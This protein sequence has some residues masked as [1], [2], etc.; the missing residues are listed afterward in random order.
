MKR[1]QHSTGK[2]RA[3]VTTKLHVAITAASHL[4]E[5][6]LSP[7]NRADVA[8]ADELF[9]EVFGCDVVE[10]TGYDSDAHRSFLGSHNNIPVIPGRK[11][12]QIAI[13]DD[14]A[15]YRLRWRIKQFFGKLQEHRRLALRYEKSDTVFLAFIALATIM[16][17][18]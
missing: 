14:R 8:V 2:H 10:D 15:L 12:R 18:I 16:M 3:G 11:H 5:G 9:A 1:G 7:G 13:S 6:F 4:V 17:L